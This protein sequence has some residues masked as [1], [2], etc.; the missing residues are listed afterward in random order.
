M[1]KGNPLGSISAR[2]RAFAQGDPFGRIVRASIRRPLLTIGA[3]AAL[4]VVAALLALR[5]EPSSAIETLVDSDSESFQATERANQVFGDDAIVILVEGDLQQSLL[6]PDLGR[7]RDLEDCLAGTLPPERLLT[8]PPESAAVCEELERGGFAKVVY[9]PAT[10]VSQSTAA[11][12]GRLQQGLADK[13]AEAERQAATAREAA[14]RQGLPK[15]EQEQVAETARQA[16]E[17][18]FNRGLVGLALQYN[19]S[20]PPAINDP[21]FVSQLVFDTA[22]GVNVPKA[23]FSYLFPSS[24]AALIQVRLRPDLTED[25]RER[26]VDLV[27]TAAAQERFQPQRGADLVVTGLPVVVDALADTVQRELAVLLVA[28][29]LVMALTLTIVFRSALRL[30]PLALAL[31][32][33]AVTYAAVSLAGGSLTMASIAALPVLI[34]LAVDYAIQF[35]SR[36][37]EQRSVRPDRPPEEAAP[38]AASAGGPTIAA[39][40]LATAVGFLVLLLSPVPMVR[41]FALILV[42]AVGLALLCT[43]TAG[44]AAMAR[45]GRPSARPADVPPVLP[46]A[47][48]AAVRGGD[49]VRRGIAPALARIDPARARVSD[50]GRSGWAAVAGRSRQ[51][52]AFAVQQPRRVLGIGLALAALGWVADTQTDVIS[53]VRELA[54]QDLEALRDLNALQEATGVSGELDVTV[55][56]ENLTD[57]ETLAWM[58]QVQAQVLAD[59]GY[60]AGETCAQA[61]GAPELC[62]ALSLPDILG[63]Q[64]AQTPEQ[65]SA[66]LDA[67]PPYFQQ[68]VVSPDRT[69]AQ[70]AFGVRLMPL[71]RQQ[72][73]VEEIERRLEGA[74][75]GVDAA[76][77][78]LPVLA[79]E[80][81]AALSSPL[82]RLLVL[83]AG[84]L[85]VFLVL[86]AIRRQPRLA[87]VPLIPIALASGWASLIL[88]LL[89]VPLNPMS[90]ALGALVIAISTE[91]SVLLSARYRE[92]RRA[93]APPRRAIELAYGSTGAAVLASGATAIAG[94]AVLMASDIRMLRD[95][96]AVTVVGLTVSLLGVMLVLPAALVWAEEHGSFELADLSPRRA[97]LALRRRGFGPRGMRRRLPS[98]SRLKR[99]GRSS[100][101]R[102]RRPR[103]RA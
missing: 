58:S 64:G 3:V 18:E 53:D 9:G 35:Q 67:V 73:L 6:T 4:A 95:F 2:L 23:R 51:A 101:P 1:L 68:A 11:I 19:V 84:L 34:G 89:R 31:A 75:E 16:V 44:F 94:F 78:G 29:I 39:A 21:S 30:L 66:L 25:Q 62:P 72:E 83:V 98:L 47:R 49:A 40:G 71:E 86:L 28:A 36:F 100:A 60:E 85:A 81:N 61:A 27:Q 12:S 80:G 33:A 69:V 8:L 7:L 38:A 26:A 46:R 87:A 55:R 65:A 70:L 97:W 82:R 45:F 57:S 56:G 102:P 77:T 50:R 22:R 37:N 90:A 79:A 74:P 59:H 43:L 88:F 103:S 92:E 24:Q 14:A 42:V 13:D 41:G 76:V 93:G 10:F 54:P 20:Q 99:A 17:A 63:P 32:A 48:A 91:F 52:L 96:G 5:L 15:R